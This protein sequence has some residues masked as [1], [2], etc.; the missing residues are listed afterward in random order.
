MKVFPPVTPEQLAEWPELAALE[1]LEATLATTTRALVA[2]NPAL[3]SP[4]NFES[5][6][7]TTPQNCLAAAV[8]SS[9]HTLGL[10]LNR[11]RVHLAQLERRREQEANRSTF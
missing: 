9:V 4:D 11:Y 8:L 1:I 7:Q 5:E 10:A 6:G 3:L 2:A